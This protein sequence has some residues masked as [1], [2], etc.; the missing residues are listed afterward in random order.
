MA[1]F[2]F[3]SIFCLAQVFL[4]VIAKVFFGDIL[5]STGIFVGDTIPFWRHFSAIPNVFLS[6]VFC[7]EQVF[8]WAPEDPSK[9]TAELN[10]L[11]LKNWV[12]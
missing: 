12:N 8:F 1:I 7:L 11:V 10:K 9:N 4:L 6:G 2:S 3:F 5:F